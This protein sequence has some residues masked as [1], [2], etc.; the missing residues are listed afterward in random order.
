MTNSGDVLIY[1]NKWNGWNDHNCVIANCLQRVNDVK[2][3]DWVWL[4]TN[5][6]SQQGGVHGYMLS[7]I[8]SVGPNM[9]RY[10]TGASIPSLFYEIARKVKPGKEGQLI[11]FARSDA[12]IVGF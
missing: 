3:G 8:T 6:L 2:V 9:I 10:T 11:D 4:D 12:R 7:R 1:Y 5:P